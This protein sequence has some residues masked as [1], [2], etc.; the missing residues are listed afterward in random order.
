MD[1]I[2]TPEVSMEFLF[3][4]VALFFILLLK[5]K[6]HV[7]YNICCQD[8]PKLPEVPR[9]VKVTRLCSICTGVM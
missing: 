6:Q 4:H 1:M 2:K 8:L 5:T 9:L 7:V 3:A